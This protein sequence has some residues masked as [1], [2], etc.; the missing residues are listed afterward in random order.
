MASATEI[1]N[2]KS[3]E[4]ENQLVRRG[5]HIDEEEEST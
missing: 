2:H 1:I 3:E 4:G 5:E